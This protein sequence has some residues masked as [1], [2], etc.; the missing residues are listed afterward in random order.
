MCMSGTL[1]FIG[2]LD[3]PVADYLPL[4]WHVSH[5]QTAL[6]QRNRGKREKMGPSLPHCAV[7]GAVRNRKV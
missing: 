1:I 3:R 6:R 4:P 7:L 5:T 2:G